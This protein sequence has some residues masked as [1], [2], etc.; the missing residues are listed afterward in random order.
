MWF[1][2]LYISLPIKAFYMYHISLLILKSECV[3]RCQIAV[4]P[5][6]LKTPNVNA[7]CGYVLLWISALCVL[8]H[9]V[10]YK[11]TLKKYYK[12]QI[13]Y[14]WSHLTD[15]DLTK[16]VV[17]IKCNIDWN[18]CFLLCNIQYFLC[19]FTLIKFSFH[20]FFSL[21]HYGLEGCR[22]LDFLWNT[23][24]YFKR[25]L[26]S[27]KCMQVGHCMYSFC[28]SI[29]KVAKCKPFARTFSFF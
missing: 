15:V 4:F 27:G 2:L 12:L 7:A 19:K 1:A 6:C 21:K 29:G 23:R 22:A 9:H 17:L 11:D 28:S 25:H 18:R 16:N 14:I 13:Q 24:K 20:Y 3:W 8:V 5:Q 26:F 10:Q